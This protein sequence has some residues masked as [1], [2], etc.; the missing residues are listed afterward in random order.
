MKAFI[1]INLNQCNEIN[2]LEEIKELEE[3]KAAYLIFGEWDILAEVELDDA[4]QIGTFVLEKL[5]SR[6]DIRLTSTLIVASR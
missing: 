4:E 1:L 3:V 2:S 6:P 5:R